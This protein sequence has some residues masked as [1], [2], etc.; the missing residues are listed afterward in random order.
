MTIFFLLV[1]TD[2]KKKINE[3]RKIFDK[4]KKF[5]KILIIIFLKMIIKVIRTLTLSR[6]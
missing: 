1:R 6:I 2:T 5:K 3:V 4:E